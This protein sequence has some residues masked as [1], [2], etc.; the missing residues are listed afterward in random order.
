PVASC[1]ARRGRGHPLGEYVRKYIRAVDE[2]CRGPDAGKVRATST[3]RGSAGDPATISRRR[4]NIFS[5]IFARW[6][7]PPPG[8]GVESTTGLRSVWPNATRITIHLPAAILAA[9]DKIAAEQR[10]SR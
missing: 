5:N 3:S 6:V 4:A 7:S 8:H 2:A 10:I 9:V 1:T